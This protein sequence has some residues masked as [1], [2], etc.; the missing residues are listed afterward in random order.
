MMVMILEGALY[1][2]DDRIKIRKEHNL[3]FLFIL[4]FI[5]SNVGSASRENLGDIICIAHA[6]SGRALACS[7]YLGL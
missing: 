4:F 5:R 3:F 1:E 6:E 2:L 7:S